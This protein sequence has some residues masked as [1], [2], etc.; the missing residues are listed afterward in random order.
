[1]ISLLHHWSLLTSKKSFYFPC[2][3]RKI[4]SGAGG[5]GGLVPHSFKG[6]WLGAKI[7]IH[8][9]ELWFYGASAWSY[10][11]MSHLPGCHQGFPSCLL[12]PKEYVL[13]LFRA[14]HKTGSFHFYSSCCKFWTEC[15][16]WWHSACF[17]EHGEGKGDYRNLCV[18][19][20]TNEKEALPCCRSQHESHEELCPLLLVPNLCLVF[21]SMWNVMGF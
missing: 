20:T 15:W 11:A 14:M 18:F 21:G 12:L 9:K 2:I 4:L 17:P 16:K 6:I 5:R 8:L 1:M 13:P 7:Y 19:I 10:L 3:R